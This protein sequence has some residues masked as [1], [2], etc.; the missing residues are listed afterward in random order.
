[1]LG[2]SLQENEL[3]HDRWYDPGNGYV[4]TNPWLIGRQIAK[5]DRRAKS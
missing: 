1:M 4:H 3:M 5:T 2:A